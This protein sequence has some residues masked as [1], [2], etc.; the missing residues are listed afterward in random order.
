MLSSFSS[1]YKN[2]INFIFFID[3]EYTSIISVSI[4]SPLSFLYLMVPFDQFITCD[5]ILL[6]LYC[7]VTV[8]LFLHPYIIAI[9]N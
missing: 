1:L 4:I 3:G 7:V 8:S 5:H 2:R 6:S 9:L